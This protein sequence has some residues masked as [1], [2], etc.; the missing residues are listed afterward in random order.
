MIKYFLAMFGI[1]GFAT[2]EQIEEAHKKMQAL[3]EKYIDD[4]KGYNPIYGYHFKDGFT[5]TTIYNYVVAFNS[6]SRYNF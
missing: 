1:V 5:S 2:A 3:M 4:T 6:H